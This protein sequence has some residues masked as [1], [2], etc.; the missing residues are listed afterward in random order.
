[1]DGVDDVVAVVV[2]AAAA[3]VFVQFVGAFLLVL[4]LELL[5]PLLAILYLKITIVNYESRLVF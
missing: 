1:M 4:G 2:V 5:Q 3:V